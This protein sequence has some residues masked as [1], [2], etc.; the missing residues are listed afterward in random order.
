MLFRQVGNCVACGN[1]I[2]VKESVADAVPQ[3]IRT[4][5]CVMSAP[6]PAPLPYVPYP[7]IPSIPPPLPQP[8]TVPNPYIATPFVCGGAGT[9]G[10]DEGVYSFNGKSYQ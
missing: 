4:C 7:W 9:Y 10:S 6:M 1:P 8:Y 2:Y 5:L 3:P